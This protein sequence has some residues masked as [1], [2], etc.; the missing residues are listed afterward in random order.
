MW[1]GWF[2]TKIIT[3]PAPC[4]YKPYQPL[5]LYCPILGKVIGEGAIKLYTLQADRPKLGNSRGRHPLLVKGILLVARPIQE[6]RHRV[7]WV[8]TF[9]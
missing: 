3:K 5:I 1:Q 6:P 7:F 2:C 9:F 4:I 8:P